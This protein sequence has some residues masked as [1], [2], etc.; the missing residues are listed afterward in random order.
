MPPP[1]DFTASFTQAADEIYKAARDLTPF[2]TS[3]QRVS[4]PLQRRFVAVSLPFQRRFNAVSM[5]LQR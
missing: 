4:M 3:F 2:L 1:S 5:P